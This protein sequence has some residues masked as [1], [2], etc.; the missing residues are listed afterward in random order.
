MVYKFRNHE[1]NFFERTHI[2]GVINV[3]PDSFSDGGKF[4]SGDTLQL[5]KII[6]SAV[7][8]QEDGADIIDVGGESTRPGSDTVSL[9]E[10]LRR[11]IPVI[12]ALQKEITIPVSIDTY[13]SKVAEE[14]LQNGAE[15]IND[16]SGLTFDENM[17]A[18]AKKNNATLIMMH[19]KGTPKNMQVNPEYEDVLSEVYQFLHDAA[20]TAKSNGITQIIVDPGIGFG[21]NL[22]HNLTLLSNLKY[23]RELGYPVLVGVSNKSF[24]DKI[25]PTPVPERLSG[26]VAANVMAVINGANIIRVHNV[27][28][29]KRAILIAE[30]IISNDKQ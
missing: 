19:I 1:Y 22:D 28:D 15:I 8:M 13:K 6:A 25:F 29:N 20:I 10:E 7:Q 11:V 16:I 26:T 27:L 12:S 30:H 3:T 2:M 17:P 18:V 5:K 4:F 9:D 23:F 21:K 14:A 24:I